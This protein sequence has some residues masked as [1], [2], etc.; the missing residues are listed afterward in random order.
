ME[1]STGCRIGLVVPRF[2]HSAVA[3]NRVKRRLRELARTYL[4][5]TGINVDIVLRIRPDAYDASF[6]SLS[7]EI[8]STVR[9]LRGWFSDEEASRALTRSASDTR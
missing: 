7:K 4:V 3:R 1:Q 2:K 8:Q 5:P 6:E 9:Q